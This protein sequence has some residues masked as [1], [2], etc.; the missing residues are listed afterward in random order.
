[1][2]NISLQTCFLD[3]PGVVRGRLQ[4]RFGDSGIGYVPV[5]VDTHWV[6]RPGLRREA[7]GDWQTWNLTRGGAPKSRYGLAG[8]VSSSSGA[9]RVVLSMK[10][11]DG[12]LEIFQSLGLHVLLQPGGGHITLQTPSGLRKKVAIF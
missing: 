5:R 2:L 7:S 12:K 8:M 10:Q 1:M 4:K 3:I 6:Y 9:A 11:S